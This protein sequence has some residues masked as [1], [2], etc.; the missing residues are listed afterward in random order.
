MRREGCLASPATKPDALAFSIAA[1]L[2]VRTADV[3]DFARRRSGGA[4]FVNKVIF[5]GGGETARIGCAELITWP[6]GMGRAHR[7]AG[8]C[9]VKFTAPD[10]LTRYRVMAVVQTAGKPFRQR[11]E[12][13]SEQPV[14]L[15]RRC[16]VRH[17]VQLSVA[18]VLHNTTD[19]A[20][21]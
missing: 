10:S 17:L 7:E 4:D 2:S 9:S 3:A 15:E 20:V 19:H 5:I 18:A 13:S 12:R 11:E 1:P 6:I 21:K 8:R 16:H 14:M